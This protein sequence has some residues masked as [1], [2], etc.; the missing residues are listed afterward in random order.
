[1]NIEACPERIRRQHN[2]RPDPTHVPRYLAEQ[3]SPVHQLPVAVLENR[4]LFHAQQRCRIPLLLVAHGGKIRVGQGRVFSTLVAIRRDH[5]IDLN[6]FPCQPRHGSP[7]S[8]LGVVRVWRNH[9]HPL[10]L[11][12]LL[13]HNVL[14]LL[15]YSPHSGESRNPSRHNPPIQTQ[16]R[17]R[18][19]LPGHASRCRQSPEAEASPQLVIIQ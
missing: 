3:L 4:H 11:P 14:P 18:A 8:N 5:V 17:V 15:T 1:M 12:K 16:Y 2:V 10:N 13:N 9:Q 19:R 7:T 6:P